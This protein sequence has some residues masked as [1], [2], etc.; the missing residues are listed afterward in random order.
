MTTHRIDISPIARYSFKG[1]R[2]CCSMLRSS[3]LNRFF[4]SIQSD[5]VDA[6]LSFFWEKLSDYMIISARDD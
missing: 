1:L 2:D 6:L 5:Y 4:F 3:S